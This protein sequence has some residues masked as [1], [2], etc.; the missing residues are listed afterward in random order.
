VIEVRVRYTRAA[1][2]DPSLMAK[3]Q[4]PMVL[5]QAL[6]RRVVERVSKQGQTATP[7]KP[8]SRRRGLYEIN[9]EYA[10]AL[11]VTKTRYGSSAQFH[12]A[13]GAKQG[14]FRVTGAMWKGLQV[15]NVG[16]SGVLIDFAGSS[17]GSQVQQSTTRSGRQR[18][19][20][21]KVRNQQKAGAVFS[22]SGV[23]VI[24]PKEQETEAMVAAVT[25]W[26]QQIV[27]RILGADAGSF[28]TTG[29][30]Q[31]LRDI[32]QHYDGSR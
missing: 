20:P 1:Q 13:I 30:Q 19:R 27:G 22:R 12:D 28:T 8:Y 23:N 14:A 26:S 6:A 24:Q 17:Y 7:A 32:L 2:A 10:R 15:R 31:L 29:D 3:L 25:R 16:S 5:G 21:T 18:A 11:G 9:S 4:Q